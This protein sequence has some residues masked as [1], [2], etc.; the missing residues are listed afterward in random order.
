MSRLERIMVTQQPDG[1]RFATMDIVFGYD[2][3]EVEQKQAWVAHH[4]AAGAEIDERI[5]DEMR[6]KVFDAY[7]IRPTVTMD[8]PPMGFTHVETHARVVDGD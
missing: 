6:D 2:N 7:G 5:L 3:L 4:V 8:D 1:G